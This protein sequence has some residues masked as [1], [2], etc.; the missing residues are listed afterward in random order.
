M[1]LPINGYADPESAEA[2]RYRLGNA[3]WG[4]FQ[5]SNV[6]LDDI[7]AAAESWKQ[8]L[9]GVDRP[10]LCWNVDEAWCRVQQRLVLEAGWTPVV[11]FD[12]RAGA[13]SLEPGAVLIDFNAN[14]N[15]PTM[16]S[17]FP[18][19]FAF[20]FTE[21]LAFWHADLLIRR[22]KMQKLARM[23]AD[24][25]DGTMAAVAPSRWN[26]RAFLKPKEQRYWELVGCTTRKASRHQF[27]QGAGWWMRFNLHPSNSP[28]Q[29]A[30]R[31]DFYWDCGTGIHF[32]ADKLGGKITDIKS[33]YVEEGHC[34][35]IN[36]ADYKR[37]GPKNWTRDLTKELSLNND[38][39]ATCARLGLSDLL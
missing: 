8:Q 1:A 35:G 29:R 34:T 13:P 22:E 18:M 20:L 21:R 10:W 31:K 7:F 26:W 5:K 25:P 33:A 14:F 27:E 23:F 9:A 12:P 37:T 24:L 19:E 28:E 11:G 17:H 38:L 15:L 30:R 2:I 39:A 3:D 32:W 6:T 36:R 16:W 4:A